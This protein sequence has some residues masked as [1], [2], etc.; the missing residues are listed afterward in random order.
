MPK[1]VLR[2][3]PRLAKLARIAKAEELAK[4]K[5]T[6]GPDEKSGEGGGGALVQIDGHLVVDFSSGDAQLSEEVQGVC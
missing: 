2:K 4:E 3:P 5:L 1:W 6:R